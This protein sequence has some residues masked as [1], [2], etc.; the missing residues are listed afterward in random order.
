MSQASDSR[1]NY[2]E[3]IK[4]DAEKLTRRRLEDANF[5]FHEE[6][7]REINDVEAKAHA[8]VEAKTKK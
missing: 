8:P 3:Q 1:R 2:L 4:E 7:E 6:K 5:D